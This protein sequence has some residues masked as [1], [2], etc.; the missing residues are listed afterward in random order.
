M[1]LPLMIYGTASTRLHSHD[2]LATMRLHRRDNSA[3]VS[4]SFCVLPHDMRDY[5]YLMIKARSLDALPSNLYQELQDIA[6]KLAQINRAKR[7]G[8]GATYRR[9][10]WRR[11]LGTT[12][13]DQIYLGA[14]QGGDPTVSPRVLHGRRLGEEE[15]EE[16]GNGLNRS[17]RPL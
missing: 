7:D 6:L 5:D 10:W 17:P 3:A 15:K 13:P 4:T 12:F 9:T 16:V 2:N 1:T 11:G 8:I 14:T